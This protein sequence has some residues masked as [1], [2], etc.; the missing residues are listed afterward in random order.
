MVRATLITRVAARLDRP[1]ALQAW[2]SSASAA[3]VIWQ[4]SASERASKRALERMDE[5]A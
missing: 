3:R 2:A 4:C 5:L 1:I